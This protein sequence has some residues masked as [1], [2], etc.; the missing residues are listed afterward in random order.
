MVTVP[1]IVIAVLMMK[2]GS[3]TVAEP[4]IQPTTSTHITG[5]WGQLTLTPIVIS[6]PMELIFSD[7]GFMR[8]PTWFFPG[9]DAAMVTRML[10]SSGV[11]TAD[12]ARLGTQARY[13]PQIAGVIVTP[14]QAWVRALSPEVRAR[15]YQ[16]LAGSEL[17]VDQSQAFRYPGRRLDDW[18]S[19]DLVSPR[20][21]QLIEPLVYR[22]GNYMLF[23]D[24]SLI[25]SE[26]GS[27]DEFRR[28]G[29]ALLQQPALIAL[30]SV[31]RKDNLNML[32]EYWG[33]GG[34]R[35]EV[36]PLLE[37]IARTDSEQ[38]ID[39]THLLPQFAQDRLYTYPKLSGSDLAKQG[40]V[41]CLW[42]SLNFFRPK[43][44]DRFLNDAIAVKTLM[45]DY[46]IVETEF[47]LGDVI[48]FLDEANNVFHAAVYI[49]DDLVFSKNGT[50]VLA[51]WT[52]MSLEDV[53]GYYRW[54]SE[55]M[56]L[57]YHRHKDL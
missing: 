17:N 31:D 45:E 40:V 30:L 52:L 54:H 38:Y 29:K 25:Q 32:V 27:G 22:H 49:A 43:P 48:A 19:S 2:P 15:I 33:R 26:I 56:R 46:F 28:L 34:R 14:D 4:D 18:L 57:V 12:A 9:A 53:K 3:R 47:E 11:S 50:S 51:P 6:P 8:R 41:N 24:V 35:T 7:W 13:E 39:V 42:T 5:T 23:S 44:D 20:I 21:R 16:V 36:R 55:N 1:W 37:S 10:Q